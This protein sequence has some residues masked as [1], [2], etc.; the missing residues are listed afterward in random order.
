MVRTLMPFV[1]DV[2]LFYNDIGKDYGVPVNE[3]KIKEVDI[4]YMK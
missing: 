2:R 4:N 3:V 1:N